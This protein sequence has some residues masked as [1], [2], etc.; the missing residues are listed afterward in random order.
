[1][2]NKRDYYEV[3]GIAKTASPEEIKKKYRKL[4][5]KYHPD[6]N[7]NDKKAEEKF[8]EAAEAYEVLSDGQKRKKYDQFGHSGM[9]GGTDYHH[10]SDIGD[11]FENFGDIFGSIFGGRPSRKA[12]K[13]GPTAQRGHDLSQ[14]LSITLKESFL[15]CKKEI[16]IYNYVICSTCGGNGCKAGTR[17]ATCTTCQGTGQT[18]S[19]QGFFAFAKPCSTCYGQG[20]KITNPCTTCRGQSRIQKHNKL[21]VN[22]PAGI[23]DKAE[24]RVAGKGDAGVFGGPSGDLFVTITVEPNTNFYRRNNDLVTTL[25]LTYP[26]LVL[27]AQIEIENIEGTK[28]IIKI[29]KGCPAGKELVIAGKGF[30]NLHSRGRGNFVIITQCDIPKK[31][32]REAKDALLEYSKRLGE[33]TSGS[34][35]GISGFFKKFL[36]VFLAAFFSFSQITTVEPARFKLFGKIARIRHKRKKSKKFFSS[37]QDNFHEIDKDKFFRSKQ[38]SSRKL[39]YYIDRFNIKTVINLRGLNE[40]SSWWKKENLT[41]KSCGAKLYNIRM[42]ARELPNKKNILY[43]LNLYDKAEKPILIHCLGGSDRTGEAAALWVIDQQKKSKKVA[44]RQLSLKYGHIKIKNRKKRAFIK[45]WN[46]RNWLKSHY[47]GKNRA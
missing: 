38:L 29:P 47:C 12:K 34:G 14:H 18:V 33:N 41:V 13:S 31:L 32:N 39:R 25:T 37:I 23:Y 16:R 30:V 2:S 46:G 8:K 21:I 10:F 15:G 36:T 3:L 45:M 24:L 26:Q 4:A 5:L 40:N 20:Y 27:G 7:P 11:I 1:M 44:L 22:I 6:R 43:L 9:Q 28:E 17:P 42:S 35:G 19:Q